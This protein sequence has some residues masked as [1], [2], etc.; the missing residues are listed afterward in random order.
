MT[1]P[2]PVDIPGQLDLL[3]EAHARRTDPDTSHAAAASVKVR[4]SQERI[5]A[6]LRRTG[7]VTDSELID[8]ATYEPWLMSPS[9]I[10]SRR[11][12]LVDAGLVEDSGQRVR[13]P[14]GRLSIVWAATD[15]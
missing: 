13:L 15:A 1:H 9:G 10:R 7:P 2:L 12:E 8:A 11:A 4:Q 14:S 6:L 5:L 3:S